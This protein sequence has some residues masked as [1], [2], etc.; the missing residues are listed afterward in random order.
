M[1]E[2]CKRRDCDR[3][4]RV[5]GFCGS[6]YTMAMRNGVILRETAEE[7]FWR[8][9]RK[10]KSGCWFW[11]GSIRKDGY[12]AFGG[13]GR[14]KAGKSLLAHRAAYELTRGAIPKGLTLDHLCRKRNCVN[15]KHL[16]PV[17]RLENVMRGVSQW[18]INARKKKCKHGHPF[19][20]ANTILEGGGRRCRACTNR[21]KRNRREKRRQI[22]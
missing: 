4:A 5:R 11:T 21:I 3:P 22:A 12:G 16:E 8:C 9:V 6:H 19:T 17:T 1:S 18:A 15:P 14:R 10:H 2:I 13:C 7:R 20:G